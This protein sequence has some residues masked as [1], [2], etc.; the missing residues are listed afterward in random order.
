VLVLGLYF[1]EQS[2]TLYIV[3]TTGKAVEVSSSA[4]GKAV[5]VKL[6]FTTGRAARVS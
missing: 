4:I 2:S 5:I 3:I 1:R 6:G